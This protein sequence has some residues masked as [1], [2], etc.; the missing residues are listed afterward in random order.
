MSGPGDDAGV[1]HV[2]DGDG[3]AEGTLRLAVHDGT[4]VQLRPIA[5]DNGNVREVLLAGTELV[6]VTHHGVGVLG[7]CPERSV[8]GR[9]LRARADLA[10]AAATAAATA[11]VGPAGLA[12]AHEGDIDDAGVDGR[13][14]VVNMDLEG[15][16]ADRRGVEVAGLQAQ[17]LRQLAGP[18]GG[19]D[20]LDLRYGDAGLDADVLDGLDVVLK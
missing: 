20:P 12:V 5:G 11:A 4:R 9:H 13:Q 3:S 19:E 17:M 1:Q 16:P 6:E 18:P 15:A 10:A 7:R 8:R 14:G 2:L